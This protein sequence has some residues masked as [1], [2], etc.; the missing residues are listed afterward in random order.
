MPWL[1]SFLAAVVVWLMLG[2]F[3]ATRAA[4]VKMSLDADLGFV[5]QGQDWQLGAET[6][7]LNGPDAPATAKGRVQ[8]VSEHGFLLGD[9]A[10]FNP[11][12]GW[13]DVSPATGSWHYL[14]LKADQ[15]RLTGHVLELTNAWISTCHNQDAHPHYDVRA[16]RMQLVDF[17]GY[18][19]IHASDVQLA[20][21]GQ[22]VMW[23]PRLDFPLD[24]LVE[25]N[26]VRTVYADQGWFSP[27]VSI[28]GNAGLA[29]NGQYRFL[30]RPGAKGYIFGEYA[31]VR[32]ASAYALTELTDGNRNLLLG[33]L[34]Y[35]SPGPVA[36]TGPWGYAR[37]VHTLDWGDRLEA[38]IGGR[39]LLGGQIVSRLPEI[40]YLSDWRSL[41]WLDTR[42]TFRAGEYLL[43]G[44]DAVTRASGRLEVS[45]PAWQPWPGMAI[46]PLVEGVARGYLQNA[47]LFG[48]G[49]QI[50][51]TQ[52]LGDVV[53]MARFRQ[54]LA[55]GPNPL[56]YENYIADQVVGG[57][58][59]WQV[60]P[61]IRL[62]LFGEWSTQRHLP[63]A[64]DLMA[65]FASDCLG[66]HV[67]YSP[68]YGSLSATGNVLAF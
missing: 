66:G 1:R 30:N 67:I 6:G 32:Q 4:G 57:M 17:Y 49:A 54:R 20:L 43:E 7:Q 21:Y 65:T 24:R 2:G 53:L 39:E 19:Y 26:K 68:L 61:V 11:T 35:Q 9:T 48:G 34:G 14:T 22:P 16:A 37:G 46:Q 52:T 50:Q 44:F 3:G 10:S 60:L 18:L 5:V 56:F 62:G 51:A 41:G 25:R 42:Y 13:V 33:V 8:I 47:P 23:V 55:Q 36:R 29:L 27:G 59:L 63:V 40:S 38:Q 15:A 45:C 28:G 58:V 31:T 64:L 12:T